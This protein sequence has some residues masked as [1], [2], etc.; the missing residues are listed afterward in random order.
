LV[1]NLLGIVNYGWISKLVLAGK[2]VYDPA[3]G[4]LVISD[5]ATASRFSTTTL[6]IGVAD[7]EKLRH[8]MAENFL[9]TVAYRGARA[10][11][12][13]PSLATSHSFFALNEHT[14]QETVRDELDVVF[15]LSLMET[16]SPTEIAMTAPEFGRTLFYAM[17]SYDNALCVS[18]FLDGNQPR[19]V[20]FYEDAG[21]QALACLVHKGDFDQARLLPTSDRKLW[22]QMKEL[23]QPTIHTLFPPDT[24]MPVLGAIVSD[25]SVIRWWSDSMHST[26][27]KLAGV[28]AFL[29]THPTADDENNDFKRLRV[30][31]ADHLRSV[32]ANTKES[33]G[34][35]WGLLAMF[36]ASGRRAG[37][38]ALLTGRNL[39]IAGEKPVES[40]I[41]TG[42]GT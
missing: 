40:A 37:R 5:T 20:E 4:Q 35:P 19:P 15:A 32:A 29:A 2:T 30:D 24:P 16:G 6:D 38:K 25:Y 21:L 13:Q 1:V 42:A 34:R 10:A 7:S 12:L 8:V 28:N 11:G 17:T 9:V 3:T 41:G 26:A 39:S 31:L 14:S 18:L 22:Q 23:G 36:I 27:E 33:F